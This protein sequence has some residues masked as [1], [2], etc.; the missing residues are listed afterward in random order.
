MTRNTADGAFQAA[1]KESVRIVSADRIMVRS[2]AWAGNL[3]HLLLPLSPVV[4]LFEKTDIIKGH[5]TSVARI[6]PDAC[7]TR[8]QVVWCSG[9]RNFSDVYWNMNPSLAKAMRFRM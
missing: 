5:N 2:I 7:P 3:P 4:V 8:S 6:A 1:K 9:H